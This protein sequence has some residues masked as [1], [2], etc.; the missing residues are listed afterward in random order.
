MHVRRNVLT[1]SALLV[2]S[3]C[4]KEDSITDPFLDKPDRAV[5]LSSKDTILTGGRDSA[6]W[7]VRLVRAGQSYQ[8]P[9]V[10]NFLSDLGYFVQNGIKANKAAITTDASGTGKIYFYANQN[11]GTARTRIWGDGFGIDTVESTIIIAPAYYM[12][13]QFRDERAT[14]WK[15]TDTLVSGARRGKPDSTLVRAVVLDRNMKAVPGVRVDLQA[16]PGGVG[17]RSFYGYF[18]TTSKV[19]ST[20]DGLVYSDVQGIAVD[21][22]YS[23]DFPNTGST[24]IKITARVDSALYGRILTSKQI[25]IKAP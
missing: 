8:K 16:F 14:D 4:Q 1:L 2:L 13:L 11:P 15:D 17:N 19:D 21:K 7:T 6:L 9:Y 12:R 25:F 5:V 24:T 3:S 22:F 20:T 18:K 10:I 23:D